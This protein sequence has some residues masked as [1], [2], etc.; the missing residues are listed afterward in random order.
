MRDYAKRARSSE[1]TSALGL[2]PKKDE[3][4]SQLLSFSDNS[5]E[6]SRISQLLA[7]TAASSLGRA[8]YQTASTTGAATVQ[9]VA[10]R[11]FVLPMKGHG[12]SRNRTSGDLK[13]LT[14]AVDESVARNDFDE[15]A[16]DCRDMETSIVQR[17]AELEGIARNQG[18]QSDLYKTHLYRLEREEELLEELRTAKK[19][20]PRPTRQQRP[21]RQSS[22]QKQ[23]TPLSNNPFAL[24]AS[25]DGE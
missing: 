18:K 8:M 5:P 11:Q 24:L 3:R 6:A 21:R 19:K 4:R 23:Q 20:A 14:Q 17:Q 9:R 16:Q 25:D 10:V 12:E 22:E 1:S 15:L 7:M 13:T 2:Q